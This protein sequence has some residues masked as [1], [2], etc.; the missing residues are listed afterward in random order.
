MKFYLNPSHFK[1]L[2]IPAVLVVCSNAVADTGDA[3]TTAQLDVGNAAQS[4]TQIVANSP[5][6]AGANT[7]VKN[8]NSML[9]A[10][11]YK[12]KNVVGTPGY[13]AEAFA[14]HCSAAIA[15]NANA[16]YALGW[17]YANGRGVAKDDSMAALLFAKA[18]AQGHPLAQEML[19]GFPASS[20]QPDLPVC[21]LPDPPKTVASTP[22]SQTAQAEQQDETTEV[23]Y[24]KGPIFKLV[25]KLAPR[26]QID[27]NL[28]MAFI[29]VE[30][31][32]NAQATSPKNAQGLMQLIPETAK[33][34]RVKNAY[35]AEDN[36]K[37]GLAYLQWLLAFFKGNVQLVAAA[38][39]SGERTVEKYKGVPPYPETQS[40]VQKIAM[41]YKKSSHPFRDDLV[42]ASSI[43]TH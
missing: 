15:G 34:F 37:G 6:A 27:T 24:P 31:G 12:F 28:A 9:V 5:D 36:I 40:Y 4:S 33:R 20:S 11:T 16:Q 17:L 22:T 23:F 13:Y 42:K 38:Y 10:P 1:L 25:D 2:L 26:Y 8:P 32:F 18:A 29:A 39:N 19:A 14:Y 21:P 43:L 30:S 3:I 7:Y 41:L 35:N